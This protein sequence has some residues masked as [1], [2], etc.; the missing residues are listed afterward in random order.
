MAANKSGICK[1]ENCNKLQVRDGFCKQCGDH[2]IQKSIVTKLDEVS[3]ELAKIKTI[4]KTVITQ[5]TVIAQPTDNTVLVQILSQQTALL[6]GVIDGIA[7][8]QGS[9]KTQPQVVERTIERTYEHADR[10]KKPRVIDDD[11]FVPSMSSIDVTGDITIVD[12]KQETIN[13]T[14]NLSSI[15]DKLSKLT[16]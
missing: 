7:S 5:P 2:F 11:V 15:A 8:L 1:V 13:D 6:Q 10:R 16:G 9:I 12:D 3:T 14:K 4:D